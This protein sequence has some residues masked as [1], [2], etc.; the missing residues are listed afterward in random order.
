MMGGL[1]SAS[2]AV[3]DFASGTEDKLK[4]VKHAFKAVT[5]VGIGFALID[6][7]QEFADKLVS[8]GSF[9]ADFV[10]GGASFVHTMDNINA[11]ADAIAN[12]LRDIGK[13]LKGAEAS[14]AETKNVK[15]DTEFGALE[16][17]QE[18]KVYLENE[19]LKLAHE[20]QKIDKEQ[21]PLERR[22]E[23]LKKYHRALDA[24]SAK[25]LAELREQSAKNTL[26]IVK[27]EKETK[28]VERDI[29]KRRAKEIEESEKGAFKAY[30]DFKKA[31][32]DLE[33]SQK[34]RTQFSLKD[35]ASMNP[36]QFRK[37]SDAREDIYDAQ[38]VQDLEAS[39]HDL[40][41]DKADRDDFIR[42]ADEVRKRIVNLRS[43][44][45]NPM[46]S[47]QE[48]TKKAAEILDMFSKEGISV[49][50]IE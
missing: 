29:E 42:Q 47:L 18:K 31:S 21:M 43:D 3:K 46:G 45:K 2:A 25:R 48:N 12:K 1:K 13:N 17:A 24:D 23:E 41:Y 5:M 11:R 27:K 50:P 15:R 19:V 4:D 32:K 49:K 35:L 7:A 9:W 16:T 33:T 22:L 28:E 20:R 37:G 36:R 44:E 38:L 8:I 6:H 34:D 39:A 40:S 10:K 26:E 14:E 30:Q